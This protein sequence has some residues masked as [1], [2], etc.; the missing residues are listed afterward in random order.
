[1]HRNLVLI[2]KL[3]QRDGVALHI[4]GIGL[5]NGGH[6]SPFNHRLQISWQLVPDRFIEQELTHIR[7]LVKALQI[8][9]FEDIVKAQNHV[10]GGSNPLGSV[11]YPPLS[12]RHNLAAGH[13][14]GIDPHFLEDFTGQAGRRAVLQFFHVGNRVDR[15]LEPTK[16]IRAHG[17]HHEGFDIRLEA[18]RVKLFVERVTT[19]LHQPSHVRH[20]IHAGTCACCR[21]GEQCSRRVFS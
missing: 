13:G 10:V 4:E 5:G 19:A 16:W 1:M 17:L 2:L 11:N 20:L 12:R 15:R 9:M 6:H 7:G 18:L 8:V 21:V 3:V 14:H